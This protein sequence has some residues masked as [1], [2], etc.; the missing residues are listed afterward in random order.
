ML[1][2]TKK[3]LSV[4]LCAVAV[5]SVF[6]VCAFGASHNNYGKRFGAVKTVKSDYKTKCTDYTFNT[7]KG[8]V[9]LYFDASSSVSDKARSNIFYGFELYYDSA[10]KKNI[11]KINGA[12]PKKDSKA[13][14]PVNMASLNS[15]NYY[16]RVYTFIRNAKGTLVID[17]DSFVKFKISV[18]KL[19]SSTP[20]LNGVT[21]S[22]KGNCI[23]WSSVKYAQGYRVYRKLY[24]DTSWTKLADTEL[25]TYT[26]GTAEC[27]LK[28]VYTVKAFDGSFASKYDKTGVT[29]IFL[30][31]PGISE[32][33]SGTDNSVIIGWG[34]VAG[35]EKYYVYKRTENESSYS[36]I[37][38]VG[39]DV[40]AFEDKSDKTDGET[41]YYKVRAV[42][43]INAGLVSKAV[44]ITPFLC[45]K[46][47]LYY[48][49]GAVTVTWQNCGESYTLYK[50]DGEEWVPVYEGED[51]SFTDTEVE[52][53][54][55]YTYSLT[56]VKDGKVSSFYSE[57]VSVTA[58][59]DTSIKSVENSVDNT[60]LI[61]WNKKSGATGY[62]IYR[63][64]AGGE[65]YEK[66]GV[67]GNVDLFYDKAQKKNN[68]KYYYAVKAFSKNAEGTLGTE[69]V[70]HL[71]MDA[72]VLSSVKVNK[73]GSNKLSWK[74]V[75][76]AISYNVYRK[77]PGGGWGCIGKTTTLS[78]TDT[79]AKKGD[80]YYYT[81][82][83]VN[84]VALGSFMSGTGVN[85]LNA[86]VLVSLTKKGAACTLSWSSADGAKGYYVY[87]KAEG[88]SFERIALTSG[89]SYTDKSAKTGGTTYVYTVKAY[90][91]S[92]SGLYDIVGL[93]VGY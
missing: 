57:G 83:A 88:G 74:S 14:V 64:V 91:G 19:G 47:S 8:N 35:A 55:K 86:P 81:V 2:G 45:V 12:F 1:K 60:V 69:T 66:I 76:G 93:S 44:K 61:K 79:K 36:R 49:D 63:R 70:A 87:R 33:V 59:G 84:G 5:L 56:A 67:T 62:E 75:S 53:D 78:F 41:L 6:S 11:V 31:A 3:I 10:Y 46:P 13:T 9:Y 24:T 29:A 89:L 15:G 90:N 85:C 27:G 77:A 54:N 42:N 17:D 40:T 18:N 7:D 20:V 43:G 58:L 80:K 72:P 92:G 25:L 51:T 65:E 21:A 22:V 82:K 37:A 71:Y 16:G 73:D 48:K 4:I 28:Y 52:E 34:E 39:K 50:K 68:L 38:A 26:D 32:P 23:S 30:D